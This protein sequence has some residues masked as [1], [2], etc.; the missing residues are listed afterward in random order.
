MKQA[1]DIAVALQYEAGDTAPQVTA[2]GRGELAKRIIAVAEQ[3][4]VP[5]VQ[6]ADLAKALIK[7]PLGFDIPEELY[8]SVAVI[9]AYLYRLEQAAKR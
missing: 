9:L 5:L 1:P 6:D 2:L 7:V 4:G 8:S 3:H